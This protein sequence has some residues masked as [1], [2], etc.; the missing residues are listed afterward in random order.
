MGEGV[1][2]VINPDQIIYFMCS[3]LYMNKVFFFLSAKT[4]L[5]GSENLHNLLVGEG[6]QEF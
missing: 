4:E 6:E 1:V 5:C 2:M 3:L